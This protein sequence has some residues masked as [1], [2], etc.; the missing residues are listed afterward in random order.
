MSGSLGLLKWLGTQL[1][2]AAPRPEVACGR[3][4][5]GMLE[6]S[7]M[8]LAAAGRWYASADNTK[9]TCYESLIGTP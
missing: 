5:F 7:N 6:G 2:L 4:V 8:K 3:I 9:M 1:R